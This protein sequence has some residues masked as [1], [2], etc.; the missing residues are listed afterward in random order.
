MTPN[1]MTRPTTSLGKERS[2]SE[3]DE[4]IQKTE[5]FDETLTGWLVA[6]DR[7]AG[8]VVRIVLPQAPLRVVVPLKFP[9]LYVRATVSP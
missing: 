5:P 7:P 8:G 2:T 4:F 3:F 6:T 9:L 1:E